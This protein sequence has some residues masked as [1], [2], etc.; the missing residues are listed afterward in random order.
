M[1]LHKL[2]AWTQHPSIRN[3]L[4]CGLTGV[5]VGILL[6]NGFLLTLDATSTTEF[7]TSCHSMQ[8]YIYPKY[9]QSVHYRN[10]KGIQAGCA[11]CHVPKPLM[12]KLMRKT[13]A[14]KDIYHTLIGTI[15]TPEKYAVHQP[16]YAKR[17]RERMRASDSRE[18]RNC[19]QE[20]YMD[21]TLQSSVARMKHQE[22][23]QQH[24][25]CVDCHEG[26]GHPSET[27]TTDGE[28]SFSLE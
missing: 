23:Q 3:K 1:N 24:K 21:L 14:L 20:A 5:I 8:N 11:D 28:K 22:G 17:V 25:T 18:C 26:V 9:Q 6:W 4:I 10:S 15:D 27:M 7:C 13:I 16:T 2:Y 12:A 19:H